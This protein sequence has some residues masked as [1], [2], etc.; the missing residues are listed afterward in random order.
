MKIYKHDS[1]ELDENLFGDCERVLETLS[2]KGV[3]DICY[4][5]TKKSFII[6]EKCDEYFATELTAEMCRDLSVLFAEVGNKI[7][8]NNR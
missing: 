1:S 4:D 7:N 2:S 6:Y 8:E 3:F 5:E